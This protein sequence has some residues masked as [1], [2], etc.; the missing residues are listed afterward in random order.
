MA[1]LLHAPYPWWGGKARVADV[2]WKAFANVAT[3]VEPFFGSGAVLLA[4]PGG[5]GKFEVVN[6]VEA[7]V[8]NFW[9]AVK[10]APATVALYCD[11]PINETDLHSRHQWLWDRVPH[12]A[13]LLE[14][15]PQAFDAQVAGYWVWGICC[16]LGDGWCQEG[17]Q[18]R[19]RPAVASAGGVHLTVKRKMPQLSSNTGIRK[20]RDNGHDARCAEWFGALR[21]RLRDVHVMCGDWRRCLGSGVIGKGEK[22]HGRMPVG[23]FFDPPYPHDHRDPNLYGGQDSPDVW[24][25]ARDWAVEHGDDPDLRVALC[26]YAGDF[27]EHPGW[28][29]YAWRGARGYAA[30]DNENRDAE[31]IWFSSACIPLVKAQGE[32]FERSA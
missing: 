15:H 14:S 17:G 31:R 22:R 21:D 28:T 8:C 10:E 20:L 13:V 16:W 24:W 11:D 12:L 32:L 29:E 23:V 4:R 2:V 3:Y 9:R 26:G 27:G 6:D 30:D 19:K 1:D 7:N 5:P 18:L 25:A